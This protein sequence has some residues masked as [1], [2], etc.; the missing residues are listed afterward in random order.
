MGRI[1]MVALAAL[2]VAACPDQ[3][4]RTGEPT[5]DPVDL[6]TLTWVVEGRVVEHDGSRWAMVGPPVFEPLALEQ[7]GEFEGTPLYAEPGTVPPFQRLYI[8]IGSGYWQMLDRVET[9][10]PV[11]PADPDV[12]PGTEG[13]PP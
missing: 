6:D 8:P 3:P 1:M 9:A 7:V 10:D 5:G 2:V 13:V 4:A 11:E 12:Q